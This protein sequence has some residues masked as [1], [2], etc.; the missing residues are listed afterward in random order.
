MM[1]A[2]VVTVPGYRS[3]GPGSI[4]RASI[5]YEKKWVCNGVHSASWVQLRSYLEG[6]V[7]AL[8]LK[9]EIMTVGMRC[10]DHETPSV[11]KSWH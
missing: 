2:S 5:F 9:P 11:C 8:V 6:I 3:R 1:S 7:A 4:P 10:A